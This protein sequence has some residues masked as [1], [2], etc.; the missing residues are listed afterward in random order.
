MLADHLIETARHWL[1]LD[2]VT[3]IVDMTSDCRVTS[4]SALEGIPL[5]RAS[6]VSCRDVMHDVRN[7]RMTTEVYVKAGFSFLESMGSCLARVVLLSERHAGLA[8]SSAINVPVGDSGDRPYFRFPLHF[9]FPAYLA[10]PPT[11]FPSGLA[12]IS[13]SA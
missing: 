11:I 8:P 9:L 7:V 6:L 2:N 10:L 13:V 4:V 12:T 3:S 5:V 1:S